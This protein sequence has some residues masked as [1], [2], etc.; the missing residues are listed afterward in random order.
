[1]FCRLMLI[2]VKNSRTA[3]FSRLCYYLS[4]ITKIVR[5]FH[6]DTG[7][8]SSYLQHSNQHLFTQV[9]DTKV[10]IPSHILYLPIHR[11]HD[12]FPKS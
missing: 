2:A 9:P 10:L 6:V 5:H 1:M 3:L 4:G 11:T 7:M 12:R 8:N